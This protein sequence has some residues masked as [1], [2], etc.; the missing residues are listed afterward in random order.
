MGIE[1][2]IFL[3][4]AAMVGW[5]ISDFILKTPSEK[6]GSFQTAFWFRVFMFTFMLVFAILSVFPVITLPDVL[7]AGIA[8]ALILGG[9]L[10]FFKGMEK[11]DVS[12]IAPLASAYPIIV[13][14][15]AIFILGEIIGLLEILAIITIIIGIMLISL[16]Q[17][18]KKL[19]LLSG[20]IWGILTMV[21]WGLGFSVLALVATGIGAVYTLFIMECFMLSYLILANLITPTKIKLIPNKVLI[22]VFGG[23]CFAIISMMSVALSAT[24]QTVSITM[25]VSAAYPAITVVLASIFYHEKLRNLQKLGVLI[26]VISLIALSM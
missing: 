25:P 4:L 10:A 18:K 6:V 13:V 19:S 15:F 5:G 17:H 14:P 3:G 23:A 20:A 24:Y 26:I 8:S 1:I 16:K 21:L 7:I 22:F 2:G 11:E 12:L 9:T